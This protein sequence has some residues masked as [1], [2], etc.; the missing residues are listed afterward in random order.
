MAKAK[1]PTF[2][3]FGAGEAE[4]FEWF[5]MFVWF[6]APIPKAKRAAIVKLAPKLCQ[7]DA[8]WPTDELLWA[9]TGDQWIQ[10]H[11]V[12]EYGTEKAKKRMAAFAKKVEED[13]DADPWGGDSDEMLAM[14]GESKQFNQDIEAWLVKLNAIHPILFAARGQDAEAGGTKL[15]AWHKASLAQWPE[16]E[17][18]I[19]AVLAAK[20]LRKDDLRVTPIAIV[21]DYIGVD[22]V[23]PK[24]RAVAKRDD[25]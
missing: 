23:S 7:R 15:S 10:Q 1:T 19:H 17:P 6:A 2:P 5:E 13:E 22:K 18:K 20:K 12:E 9:S 21:A 24:T 8:Q 11:L 25:G 4:Y 14:G 16:I 3:F